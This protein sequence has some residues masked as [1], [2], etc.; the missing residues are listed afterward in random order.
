MANKDHSS[1]LDDGS[2]ETVS[3]CDLPVYS[4]DINYSTTASEDSMKHEDSFEF[5]NQ[6]WLN[7]NKD[8]NFFPNKDI[9]FCGNLILPKNPISSKTQ[10]FKKVDQDSSSC[11]NS[12]FAKLMSM[13]KGRNQGGKHDTKRVFPASGSMKSRWYYYGFGLAGIPTEMDISA[14]KSR[15]NRHRKSQSVSEQGGGK[16]ES[17]GF[18]QGKRLGR[19]IRE[20]SCDGQT[21]ADSMVKSSFVYV[22]RKFG[23]SYDQI[24]IMV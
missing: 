24:T 23:S 7:N 2:E 15:Q 3:L 11:R 8:F 17:G 9:L 18:R 4:D 10:E 19:L 14:I 13:N 21:Q 1:N 22:P 12:E 16:E 6:E 20:L 5:F